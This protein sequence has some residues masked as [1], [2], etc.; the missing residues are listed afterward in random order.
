F[1]YNS[2]RKM[3]FTAG[4]IGMIANTLRLELIDYT[5][6]PVAAAAFIGAMSAG[7]MASAMKAKIGYPRITLT[8]PSI[9]IMVPGMFMYKGIYYIGLNDISTGGLWLSKAFL[10]VAALPLGLIFARIFTDN[11]FRKSS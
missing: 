3:A 8:V 6:I 7:L 1:L 9:V 11:N 10:I 5:N 2:K 4:L